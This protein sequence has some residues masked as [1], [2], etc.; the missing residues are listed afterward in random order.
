MRNTNSKFYTKFLPKVIQ[1]M[2][3]RYGQNDALNK[4]LT[5]T[6][7]F[8]LLVSLFWWRPIFLPLAIIFLLI[9]WFRLYSKK[10]YV[11]ANENQKFLKQ[12]SGI[13]RFFHF[14]IRAFKERKTYKYFH[15]KNCHQALR[16]PRGRGA[17]EVTCKNCHQQMKTKS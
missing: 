7:F 16:V 6:G 8:F 9:S 5:R 14:Y 15:C 12:T 11:R 13:H 2:K 10:I 17:L 1:F 4:F 3:G